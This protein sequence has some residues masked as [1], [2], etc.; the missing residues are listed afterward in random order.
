M[1]AEIVYRIEESLARDRWLNDMMASGNDESD[2]GG[3]AENKST[4]IVAPD[5]IT[6]EQLMRII[7]DA[8]NEGKL[9]TLEKIAA[10]FRKIDGKYIPFKMEGNDTT[11]E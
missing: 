8:M 6:E 10:N 2:E 5:G 11:K 3:G 1:N 7:N 9:A 4:M